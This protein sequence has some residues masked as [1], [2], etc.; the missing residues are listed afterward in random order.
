MNNTTS[1]QDRRITEVASA[2]ED[3]I[4]II[5]EL[6]VR[7]TEANKRIDELEHEQAQ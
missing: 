3:L 1:A 2:V 7:L 5:R 6:D 4:D